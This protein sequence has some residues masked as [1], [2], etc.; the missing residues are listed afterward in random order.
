MRF[1]PA[2]RRLALGGL[3][4]AAAVTSLAGCFAARPAWGAAPLTAS[5][6]ATLGDPKD[7]ALLDELE[8]AHFRY[9]VDQVDPQT[10]LARDRSNANA[11]ASIAAVGFGLSSYPIAVRRGWVD[12]AS[13]A[14]LTRK[15]LQALWSAPQGDAAD[16]MAGAHGL[17]YHFLDSHMSRAW[18]CE[19]STID[20]ALL[21]AGVRLARDYYDQPDEADIRTLADQLYDRVDWA[22][23]TNGQ[24][25]VSLGWKPESGFLAYGWGGYNEAMVLL[26]LGLGSKTHPLP[27]PA[28]AAFTR[29]EHPVERF[30]QKYVPFAPLFGHQYSHAW[31]DFRGIKD[32]PMRALGF[33]YFENSRR[34]TLAQHA[35]ALANVG[36]WKGY[37]NLDWGLTA[38]DGPGDSTVV[39]DGKPRQFFG[40]LARGAPDGPDDG[41]LA[42]TAAAASL[43]FAPEIVLPTLRHWREDRPELWGPDGFADAF[44]PTSHWV[45][46]ERLGI[47]QGPIVLMLENYRTGFVWDLMRHDTAIKSG[48]QRAGFTG[49]W[50]QAGS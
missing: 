37:G 33:D 31:V 12:R 36:G 4:T 17:F 45:D 15:V 42:P 48:L 11:P 34:A 6:V 47:D 10:G 16:G 27:T 24:D 32:A 23:A 14:G 50:L 19:L 3:A 1:P 40:Y 49:G 41:T 2:F 28:W 8:R 35:Y 25:R 44:N 39:I 9:F 46:T 13:A 26:L 38:C 30:G 18:H 29:D 21:M 7:N 20:T 22:W 43:P 5:R